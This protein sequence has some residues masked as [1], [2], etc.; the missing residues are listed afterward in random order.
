M[1]FRCCSV[2]VSCWRVDRRCCLS[3]AR[4]CERLVVCCYCLCCFVV[5]CLV[6]VV[7]VLALFLARVSVCSCCLLLW[8]MDVGVVVCCV[9]AW[10]FSF[11][12][13]V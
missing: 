12:S 10:L 4:L 3:L 9:L 7:C 11:L 8:L 6:L 1:R 2:A 5:V 13:A